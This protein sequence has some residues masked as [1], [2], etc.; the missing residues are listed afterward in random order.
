MYAYSAYLCVYITCLN[1]RVYMYVCV[2]RERYVCVS[3]FYKLIQQL[4]YYDKLKMQSMLIERPY[5]SNKIE[6]I[7][8]ILKQF[9]KFSF[10]RSMEQNTDPETDTHTNLLN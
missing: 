7:F 9:L 8:K 6:W 5:T 4:L 2:S 3:L 10:H 1:T